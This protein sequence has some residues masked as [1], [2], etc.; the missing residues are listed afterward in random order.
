MTL[1]GDGKLGIGTTNPSYLV[2][3]DAIVSTDPSYIVAGSGSDFVM[4]MGSQNSPG[5]AQEAFIGTL[6]DQRF[7]IKVNNTVKGS[8]TT[9]GLAIGTHTSASAPLDVVTNSNVYAAEFTQSN[10]SNGDGVFISIGS[11]AAA[12][13][14]LTVRSD[15]GNH[16]VLAAKANGNVGIGEFV[17]DRRL[18]VNGGT[19][20]V[21][22]KLESTDSIAA[23]EFADPNGS[24]EIGNNGND[25]VFF[26]AGADKGRFHATTGQFLVA[27]DQ[28]AAN[29]KVNV[30]GGIRFNAFSPG[31]GL[32]TVSYQSFNNS[33]TANACGSVYYAMF[34]I[35]IYHNNGHS[36]CFFV[37]NGGGGVGFNFTGIVPGNNNL[38]T[39]TGINTSFTTIGSQP[40]TFQ[41]QISSGG[42][43]LTVSRSN[44]TGSFAVSVH[45]WAGG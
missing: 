18:H 33:N 1:D 20:N 42:G 8:W 7:K 6:S 13:Y 5:V 12:D 11:T 25:L 24:A 34:A 3:A 32:N 37:S 15:N 22:A 43:A 28:T 2:H 45:K 9:G 17:P 27:T 44:G 23:I 29:C 4:A 16:S 26:P 40:N 31:H 21:V 30:A 14:A 36:Q 10:T 38:V 35:N 41:I 19:T 39:G